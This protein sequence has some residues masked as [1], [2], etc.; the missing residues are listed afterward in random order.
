MTSRV[1]QKTYII[2]ELERRVAQK[3]NSTV[4]VNEHVEPA[5][6]N[7]IIIKSNGTSYS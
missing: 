3:A 5:P 6:D 7:A 2:L 1:S 4:L